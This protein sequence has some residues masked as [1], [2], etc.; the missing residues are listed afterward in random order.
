M[1][2]IESEFDI[3]VYLRMLLIFGVVIIKFNKVDFV[4]YLKLGEFELDRCIGL[5]VCDGE[6]FDVVYYDY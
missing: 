2:F 1:Y 6:S 3:K 5:V 4:K